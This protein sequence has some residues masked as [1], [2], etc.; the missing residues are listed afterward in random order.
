M[1]ILIIGGGSV[2]GKLAKDL[3]DPFVLIESDPS[4]VWELKEMLKDSRVD[5]KI[6]HGD[7]SSLSTIKKSG[8]EFDAAVVLM[9]KDFE[10]L[11]AVSALKDVGVGRVI[12]RV[13]RSTNMS[14]F[15]ELGAEVFVHPIGYE[16][17]LIRTMLYPDTSHAIQIFVREGSPAIGKTIEELNLPRGTVIGSILRGDRMIA[18]EPSMEIHYGDLIAVDAVGKRAK[19]VWKIFSREG[20]SDTAGHLIFPLSKD[21][22]LVSLKEVELL[23]KRLGSEIIFIVPPGKE[24]LLLS[25]QGF[26]SKRIH[27]EVISTMS[28]HECLLEDDER[29]VRWRRMDRKS[30]QINSIVSEHM[31]EASAHIDVLVVPPPKN[32]I[33]YIPFISTNLDRIIERSPMPILIARN[34]KTYR[35]IAL[36]I[37]R[38]SAPEINI[39]IQLARATGASITALTQ[40]RNRKR[41]QY[42]QRFAQVYKVDVEI[43]KFVGNPTVEFIRKIKENHYDLIIIKSKLKELQVSQMRRL[44]HLW[45]GSVLIVP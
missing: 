11:E 31:D 40:S 32:P 19:K 29:Q 8:P 23:A 10:N 42:L 26:I 15:V 13:N 44:V 5:H 16:E 12:A 17:G 33:V 38:H 2:G 45:N 14:R 18:P 22:D 21:R 41:A 20:K 25:A 9:N 28:E 35:N 34:P 43:E 3:K 6:V 4:R 1:R 37:H 30:L 36:Y 7:G 24:N 39:A 27:F